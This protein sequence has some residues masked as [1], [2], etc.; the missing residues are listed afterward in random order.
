MKAVVYLLVL[1]LLA[2][3]TAARVAE[4]DNEF[5][6]FEEFDDEEAPPASQRPD[7]PP[8]AAA[9]DEEEAR[10]EV[11]ASAQVLVALAIKPVHWNLSS[12]VS[13]SAHGL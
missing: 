9:D 7:A 11:F 1:G 13:N 10:V 12:E 5:A 4:E 8:P 3:A 2:G 6:E